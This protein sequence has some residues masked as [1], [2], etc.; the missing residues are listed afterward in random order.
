MILNML[1]FMAAVGSLSGAMNGNVPSAII[2][3]GC[4]IVLVLRRVRHTA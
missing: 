4:V 2:V 3:A 1:V